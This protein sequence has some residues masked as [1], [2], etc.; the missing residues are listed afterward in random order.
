[1]IIAVYVDDLKINK[2][3]NELKE[4]CAYLKNE[5]L[6]KDLGETKLFIGLYIGHMSQG[7]LIQQS[8][9]TEKGI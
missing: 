2:T 3:L 7:V 5:F 9:D 8:I 1:M 6:M 4:A